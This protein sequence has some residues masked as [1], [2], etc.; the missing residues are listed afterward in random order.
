MAKLRFFY[1]TCSSDAPCNVSQLYV[2][3]GE[4]KSRELPRSVFEIRARL[5]ECRRVN[6]C[7]NCDG[8]IQHTACV[9]AKTTLLQYY[10]DPKKS[11]R[12]DMFKEE[13]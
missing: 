10:A 9:R 3:T 7:G 2:H 8:D 13:K 1:I 5:L 4:P 11:R 6:G 12:S